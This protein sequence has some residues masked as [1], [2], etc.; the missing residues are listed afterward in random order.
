MGES[1]AVRFGLLGAGL[2]AP[3]HAK[4][5]AAAEGCELA[6]IADLNIERA[7]AVAAQ[8]GC[9]AHGS[10]E[11][12]LADESVDVVNIVTPNHL[13]AEPA[14]AAAKGGKHVLVEKPPAMSLADVD[15]MVEAADAAGVKL[16]C[17]LNCRVRKA[18][19]AVREALAV[20]RFGRILQADAYMKWYRDDEYYLSN[21]WHNKRRTGAGVTIMQLFHYLDLL[22]YFAG[23]VSRVEAR[24]T[25]LAHPEVKLDDTAMAFLNYEC[26]TV[27]AV[28]AST[29][30]WPGT[31]A[32]LEI[33]GENG[34]A[35]MV[36]E[37]IAMWNFRDERPEDEAIR[38]IGSEAVGTGATGAADINFVG[39]QGIIEGMARA[40]R[41]DVD[42]LVTASD[43]RQTLELALAMYL[44][45][46]RGEPVDLPLQLDDE[47]EVWRA[48]EESGT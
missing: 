36:G 40:V 16:G 37:R 48:G 15:R 13:H 42:P 4:A 25:N 30:L 39:H 38:C 5:I 8:F 45:A 11:E 41:E 12:L 2:I 33:N 27:G 3:F 31:A 23:P 22:R 32:R 21:D 24:M 7:R 35:I 18:V 34:T 19:Q 1:S 46:G 17:V 9:G 29:A 6:A 43:A 44:A 14:I 47:E 20:G 26:G 10:L 28:V